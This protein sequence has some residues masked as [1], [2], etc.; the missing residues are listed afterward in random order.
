ML[1]QNVQYEISDESQVLNAL[2]AVLD[3]CDGSTS[4]NTLREIAAPFADAVG[5]ALDVLRH[6]GILVDAASV[7]RTVLALGWMTRPI[8]RER[9]A[10]IAATPTWQ[11][12]G[13]LRTI[14]E[15]PR[16]TSPRRPPSLPPDLTRPGGVVDWQQLA[17][18]L[19]DAYGLAEDGRREVATAGN[20]ADLELHGWRI[21]GD[22]TSVRGLWLNARLPGLCDHGMECDVGDFCRWFIQ[23]SLIYRLISDGGAVVTICTDLRRSAMKYGNRAALFAAMEAG[24]V[25]HAIGGLAIQ[26]GINSRPMGGLLPTHMDALLERGL[27][28]LMAVLLRGA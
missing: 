23:D 4:T 20:L 8:G 19:S 7:G 5:E 22:G 18:I 1:G 24:A 13:S 25:A 9:L 6:A 12:N 21:D 15:I 26:R 10:T 28:P 14:V 27:E 17:E 11:P 3:R 2:C 16:A